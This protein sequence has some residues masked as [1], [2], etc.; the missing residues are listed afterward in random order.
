MLLLCILSAGLCLLGFAINRRY[1]HPLCLFNG[2]W[3]FILFLY[4]LQL[5][6]TIPLSGTTETIMWIM[7]I[8]FALGSLSYTVLNQ[9]RRKKSLREGTVSDGEVEKVTLN[10]PVF[11]TMCAITI[12]VLLR[13]EVE[14]IIKLLQGYS[15]LDVMRDAGGKQT[16]TISGSW[17]VFLYM[18]IV[19]P[20]SVCVHPICAIEYFADKKQWKYLTVDLIIVALNVAHHGGR[21]SIIVFAMC[22]VLT[23]TMMG[24][25]VRLT[26]W[27]KKWIAALLAGMAIMIFAISGSR[28]IEQVWL[29]FYA[30]L[31]TAIPLSTIYL[32][33][34]FVASNH[35]Y[36]FFSFKGIFYPL[37]TIIEKLGL[38]FP[39]AYADSTTIARIIEDNYVRIGDYRAT[40]TNAFLPA[41]AYFYVDGGVLFEILGMFLYGYVATY[42]FK[43]AQVYKDKRS[44]AL[45][46]MFGYA[47]LLSF[48]RLYFTS[49]QHMLGLL[50]LTTF[51]YS[52][53]RKNNFKKRLRFG[54]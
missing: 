34:P 36:G 10:K 8:C 12:A 28:G 20:F 26:K 54:K 40:G 35:T 31:I 38:S 16:V 41:G 13:D 6:E 24:K 1:E 27:Q 46:I 5:F 29:S 39:Q 22:Y 14:I 48:T 25:R 15:F 3:A 18:F 33:F 11:W 44:L 23:F 42:L 30:Y 43:R 51:I 45:Y 52:G 37:N 2:I 21:N 32:E 17:N 49:Y 19:H 53:S 9:K 47:L 50:Y 4:L 7:I